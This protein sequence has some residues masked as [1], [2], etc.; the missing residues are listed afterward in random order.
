MKVS[1]SN[2]LGYMPKDLDAHW[3]ERCIPTVQQRPSSLQ[4]LQQDRIET[5]D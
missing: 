3:S 1:Q 5:I 2:G 4:Q